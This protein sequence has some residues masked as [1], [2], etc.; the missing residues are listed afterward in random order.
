MGNLRKITY[1]IEYWDDYQRM[2]IRI[3][4]KLLLQIEALKNYKNH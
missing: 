3:K 1:K 2:R 4:D